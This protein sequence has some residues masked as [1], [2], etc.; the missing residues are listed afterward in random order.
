MRSAWG[1]GSSTSARARLG[2][3]A[4][5]LALVVAT[6]AASKVY[7]SQREALELAFPDAD[8][9]ERRNFVLTEAQ[10]GR[11]E[12]A[13]RAPLESRIVTLHVGWRGSRVLGY[14]LIDIHTVRT[15]P[16]ALM[17]VL[18]ADGAVRFVR[19]LAF[20]EPE[21][22]RPPDRWFEQFGGRRLGPDLQLKRGVDAISGATLSARATTRSVR[23]ALALYRVLVAPHLERQPVAE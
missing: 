17:T 18:H 11:I 15:L 4:L 16:E 13:A 20:H 6:P 2:L 1:S 22:Y 9:V 23:R 7:H 12:Q 21:D 8:R 3:G 14:A 10:T 5:A 19:V